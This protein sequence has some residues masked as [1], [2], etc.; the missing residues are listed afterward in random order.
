M[1][2]RT[3]RDCWSADTERPVQP[4]ERLTFRVRLLP[5]PCRHVPQK[6]R[7][8]SFSLEAAE[9]RTIRWKINFIFSVMEIFSAAP[10]GLI[11]AERF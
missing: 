5:P 9:S 8:R 3:E 11:A 7:K 4:G 10:A 1:R 2:P 6:F